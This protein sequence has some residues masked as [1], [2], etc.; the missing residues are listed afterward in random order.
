MQVYNTRI[1]EAEA[2]GLEVGGKPRQLG[3]LISKNIFN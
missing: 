1:W 2:E 3:K